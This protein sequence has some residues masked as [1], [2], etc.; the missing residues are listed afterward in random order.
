MRSLAPG[1]EIARFAGIEPEPV[2][3]LEPY[4]IR[5]DLR[6]DC[7]PNDLQRRLGNLRRKAREWEEEQRLNVLFLAVGFLFVN[8]VVIGRLVVERL[9]FVER[10]LRSIK[11]IAFDFGLESL[12]KCL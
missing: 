5:H 2:E 10:F 6:G 8:R 9:N 3:E 1:H 4:V 12:L 7:P 11:I